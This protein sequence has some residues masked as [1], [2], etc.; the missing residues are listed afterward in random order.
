MR[1][2]INVHLE[3]QLSCPSHSWSKGN[4]PWKLSHDLLQPFH[5]PWPPLSV[6][7]CV[8]GGERHGDRRA[9]WDRGMPPATRSPSLWGPVSQSRKLPFEALSS[10]WSVLLP[11]T[12]PPTPNPIRAPHLHS[13]YP[14]PP[15]NSL[16]SP[17]DPLVKSAVHCPQKV[18]PISPLIFV[19]SYAIQKL[20]LKKRVAQ[21]ELSFTFANQIRFKMVR[22]HERVTLKPWDRH[23]GWIPTARLAQSWVTLTAP[24]CCPVPKKLR[25]SGEKW[26]C[27]HNSGTRHRLHADQVQATKTTADV[28]VIN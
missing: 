2:H 25:R 15:C 4:T 9:S 5:A 22:R 19:S 3:F 7:Y 1:L 12:Q 21:K 17:S 10:L 6:E 24:A 27:P 26:S 8:M 23:A 28:G 14:P 16:P 18:I 13:L 20:N 11:Q